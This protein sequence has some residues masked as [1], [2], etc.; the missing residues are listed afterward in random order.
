M[1]AVDEEDSGIRAGQ[2][3]TETWIFRDGN[4]AV[5]RPKSVVVVLTQASSKVAAH[6][7]VVEFESLEQSLLHQTRPF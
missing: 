5:L 7:G 4:D 1:V 2:P 6:D 3:G